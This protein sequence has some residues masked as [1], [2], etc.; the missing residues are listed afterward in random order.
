MNKGDVVRYV[1]K[2]GTTVSKARLLEAVRVTPYQEFHF[3]QDATTKY[4]IVLV[5]LSK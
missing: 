1:I 4:A 2:S 5:R 3:A